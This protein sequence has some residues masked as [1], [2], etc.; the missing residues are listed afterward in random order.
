M[1]AMN[2]FL[3]IPISMNGMLDESSKTAIKVDKL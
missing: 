3:L 2:S 1:L